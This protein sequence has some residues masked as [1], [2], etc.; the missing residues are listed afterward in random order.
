MPKTA[1]CMLGMF[2]SIE[3]NDLSLPVISVAPS[4][5]SGHRLLD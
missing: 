1:S 4:A 5:R 3:V 2:T